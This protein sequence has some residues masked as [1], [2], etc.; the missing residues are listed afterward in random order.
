MLHRA[1]LFLTLTG[2]ALGTPAPEWL[3]QQD[4]SRRQE[5]VDRES[6]WRN[7]AVVYQIFVDRF[8]PSRHLDQKTYAAPRRLR[9]WNEMPVA[10]TYLQDAGVWSHE[11]DYWGGD[12]DS[13]RSKLDYLQGLGVDVV[14]LNPIFESLTNHKYDAWDYHKVDPVYGTRKD[15]AELAADLHGRKMKLMLDGVFNHVGKRSPYL[16]EHRDFFKW[17]NGQPVCWLDV[18]NLPELQMENPKVREFI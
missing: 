11:V 12:L 4:L 2:M 15:V 9:Q 1:L 14:Y 5:F 17:I 16:Q 7:G 18:E 10:G 13:V 3:P 8:A 6:D